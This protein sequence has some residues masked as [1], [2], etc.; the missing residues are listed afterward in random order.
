MLSNPYVD[1]YMIFLASQDGDIIYSDWEMKTCSNE[2]KIGSKFKFLSVCL[3]HNILLILK[4]LQLYS[5]F[6]RFLLTCSY[7]SVSLKTSGF[8]STCSR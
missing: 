8:S 7:K 2:E 5:I 3:N 1:I 6:L 4:Y